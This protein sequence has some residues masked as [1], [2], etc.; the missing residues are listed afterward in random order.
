WTLLSVAKD[1][2]QSICQL[3]PPFLSRTVAVQLVQEG[4]KQPEA[5]LL[6]QLKQSAD[7]I[8]KEGVS[9]PCT[10][11]QG[12]VLVFGMNME[13]TAKAVTRDDSQGSHGRWL[14]QG[15]GPTTPQGPAAVDA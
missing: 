1:L 10:Q 13:A 4:N 7:G 3:Y 2:A 11:R 15:Q 9:P 12:V 5:K 6:Q 14:H 8:H